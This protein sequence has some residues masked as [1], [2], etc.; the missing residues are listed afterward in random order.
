M[1]AIAQPAGIASI[2]GRPHR[3]EAA[4]CIAEESTD[5]LAQEQHTAAIWQFPDGVQCTPIERLLGDRG[6]RPRR[7]Q[8]PTGLRSTGVR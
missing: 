4:R 5:Q 3:S 7:V 6:I 1:R 2:H 8:W